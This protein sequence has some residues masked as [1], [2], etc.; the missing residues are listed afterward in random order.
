MSI[1]GRDDDTFTCLGRLDQRAENIEACWLVGPGAGLASPG[2]TLTGERGKSFWGPLSLV[3]GAEAPLSC[4]T[5]KLHR[6]C[7]KGLDLPPCQ[8]VEQTL[9]V[10]I[11]HRSDSER[12]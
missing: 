4:I 7:G 9:K 3:Q 2:R 12:A 10:E 5:M 11:D 1:V 6:P 8:H